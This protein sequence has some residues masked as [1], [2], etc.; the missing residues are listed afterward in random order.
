MKPFLWTDSH[1]RAWHLYD[2]RTLER[3]RR[4]VPIGD[5]RAEGRAF[6]PVEGGPVLVYSFGPVSYRQPLIDKLIEDQ[7]RFAKPF[8]APAG[9]RMDR[10]P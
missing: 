5:A 7:L 2:F 8:G 1:G 4:G 3:K 9:Q 10:S 6:V